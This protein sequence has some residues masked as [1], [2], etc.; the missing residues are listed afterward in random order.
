VTVSMR[1]MSAG[2]GYKYLLRTV[3]AGDGDRSLSTPLTRYYVEAGTPWWS[4]SSC[5]SRRVLAQHE[6]TFPTAVHRSRANG[7]L[8][9]M[10][11]EERAVR[12][13]HGCGETRRCYPPRGRQR[14][15]PPSVLMIWPVIQDAS[16]VTSQAMSRA[17]SSG[18]PYRPNGNIGS[19]TCHISS[20]R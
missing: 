14:P 17:G 7:R 20:L 6:P 4:K 2:D 10:I 13:E 15:K 18:C 19:T 5:V 3:A 12:I 9:I 1:L 11:L 16:S 8:R